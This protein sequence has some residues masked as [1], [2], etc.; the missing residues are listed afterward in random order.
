MTART[1]AER[2]AHANELIATGKLLEA[3]DTYVT[4]DVV[5]REP[6]MEPCV[7]KEANRARELE[8]LG[9]VAEFHGAGL[10]SSAVGDNVSYSEW[11][12]DITFKN[13]A[14]VRTEQVER[15]VWRDGQIVDV[16]FYYNK[17]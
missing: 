13:G 11:W 16:R 12:F 4:D 6:G 3:F 15:R 9:A 8:F 2:D 5:M 14:R 17:G 1:L 7:G 10:T